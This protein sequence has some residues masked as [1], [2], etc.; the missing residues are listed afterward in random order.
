MGLVRWWSSALLS[1]AAG[2]SGSTEPGNLLEPLRRLR[3]YPS[4]R[5]SVGAWAADARS[6]A[7]TR[8]MFIA[9]ASRHPGRLNQGYV[10]DEPG[11][12]APSDWPGVASGAAVKR[13][14]N[15]RG[16]TNVTIPSTSAWSWSSC[17]NREEGRG[18]GVWGKGPGASGP[19]PHGRA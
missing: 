2:A 16:Q 11:Q 19:F 3:S 1:R 4:L 10:Q 5:E 6:Q 12:Q 17:G 9:I 7:A 13:R 14:S 18:M 8:S 15:N